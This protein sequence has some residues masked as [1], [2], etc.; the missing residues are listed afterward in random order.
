MGA[1][2][3][4]F[5]SRHVLLTGFEALEQNIPY[6]KLLGKLYWEEHNKNEEEKAATANA[7]I[8][9]ASMLTQENERSYMEC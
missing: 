8:K 6:N 2:Q 3:K 1:G 5:E 4:D 9:H 7:K